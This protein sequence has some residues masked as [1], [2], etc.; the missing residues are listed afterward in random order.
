VISS[1]KQISRFI[2]SHG[3][4][5]YKTYFSTV[6]YKKFY[7][8]NAVHKY[9]CTYT[10]MYEG[11]THKKQLTFHRHTETNKSV[12]ET[13]CTTHTDMPS[14]SQSRVQTFS[15]VYRRSAVVMPQ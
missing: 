8:T 6:I 7:Q 5:L 14:L 12:V 10:N 2:A 13:A 15:S 9:T 3:C 11:H 4:K 1:D